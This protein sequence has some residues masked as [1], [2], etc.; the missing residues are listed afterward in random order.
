MAWARKE[1]EP[2]QT[3]AVEDFP[4]TEEMICLKE[5][6]GIS[7]PTNVQIAIARVMDGIALGDLW[8]DKQVRKALGGKKPPAVQ[9][10]TVVV[11]AGTR[12]GKSILASRRIVR[13]A[14]TCSLDGLV[15]GDKVKVPCLA[16]GLD[17]ADYVYS[18]ALACCQSPN[19]AASIVGRP[20]AAKF[21][22]A[23]QGEVEDVEITTQ[24]LS[25]KGSNLVG[26]WLGGAAFDEA[27]RMASEQ[28]SVRSLKASRRSVA[29][30]ILA[31]GQEL[32]IGSPYGPTGD[33]Y[34][35][36]RERFGHPDED[37]VVIQASGPMLNPKH[38]TPER[39]AW[40]KK[41]DPFVYVTSGL[42]EFA[43][44]PDSLVPSTAVELAMGKH[45]EV[46]PEVD[47]LTGKIAREYVAA[48][49]AAERGAGWTLSIVGTSGERDGQRMLEQAVSKQWF[50][51]VGSPL[52]S[53]KVLKETADIC[54]RYG[55]EYVFINQRF[56][57][58]YIEAANA[59]GL[60][61]C[62]VDVN[63]D[64]RIEICDK[65]RDAIV[66]RRL[67][68]TSS[69]QQYSDLVHVQKKQT[70]NGVTVQY[71]SSGEGVSCDFIEP[72]GLCVKYA[73][74][75]PSSGQDDGFGD[76]GSRRG[77]RYERPRAAGVL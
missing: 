31:G 25:S 70:V 5:Y 1:P 63:A 6:G 60:T 75:A 72:V 76:S 4:T 41:N 54:A 37:V 45:D 55:L 13:S 57:N 47:P 18:H 20:L 46:A 14:F 67:S 28:D 62:G 23:R 19:L 69:R 52:E 61:L 53:R 68:L 26:C 73:P 71:P 15:P 21:S 77:R 35:L 65:L 27:P 34:E 22:V 2:A 58:S 66:E 39:L 17:T 10:R 29:D 24:A 30:R 40:L 9:P 56:V 32:L 51:I 59:A 44:P 33:V 8:K 11:L 48:L 43:D 7:T 50:N 16:T 74:D 12:G 49:G 42:G 3:I 38:W 36:W 64:E